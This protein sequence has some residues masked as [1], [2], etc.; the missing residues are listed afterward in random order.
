MSTLPFP[1]SPS[2]PPP[3][4]FLKISLT[5]CQYKCSLPGVERHYKIVQANIRMNWLGLI[6]ELYNMKSGDLI[7]SPLHIR[8]NKKNHVYSRL[9]NSKVCIYAGI[10]S[11]AC[12]ILVFPVRYMLLG[13]TVPKLLC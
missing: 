7:T 10:S 12:E 6:P 1:P 9:L 11:S 5:D 2:P 4:A 3:Q 13:F 8:P